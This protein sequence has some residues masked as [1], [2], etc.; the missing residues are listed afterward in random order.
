MR[1]FFKV[2][3]ERVKVRLIVL[4]IV[5]LGPPG[6]TIDITSLAS[7]WEPSGSVGNVS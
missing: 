7:P 2:F 1:D 6:I 4:S 5:H 3:F